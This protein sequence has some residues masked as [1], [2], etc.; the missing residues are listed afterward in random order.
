[1]ITLQELFV[2]RQ[3]GIDAEGRILGRMRG[4]GLRPRF[5]DHFEQYGI[6]LPPDIFAPRREGDR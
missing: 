1:M 3:V 6:H 2:F 4:T 5:A